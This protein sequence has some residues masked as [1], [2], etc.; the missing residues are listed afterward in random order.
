LFGTKFDLEAAERLFGS[1][2]GLARLR[3]GDDPASIASS[4]AA[5]EARW[6]LLRNQYLLYR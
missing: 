5:G 3:A 1:K 2:E 6:R 4:W